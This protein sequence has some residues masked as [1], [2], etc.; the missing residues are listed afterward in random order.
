MRARRFARTCG[1]LP[2]VGRLRRPGLPLPEC[3]RQLPC[4]PVAQS[5]ADRSL[6]AVSVN[7][8]GAPP[9]K[10]A[11]KAAALQPQHCGPQHGALPPPLF[12]LLLQPFILSVAGFASQ[13]ATN[14]CSLHT[15][16]TSDAMVPNRHR[17]LLWPGGTC[18]TWVSTARHCGS[19][20]L[21][22]GG[23]LPE[24]A[25]PPEGFCGSLRLP[26]ACHVPVQQS[27]TRF[28]STT[29]P[30]QKHN[31]TARYSRRLAGVSQLL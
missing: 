26:L 2:V 3:C 14:R 17:L 7:S 11:G 19:S 4:G 16:A 20:H 10:A 31:L 12:R 22:R 9:G 23:P 5:A 1:C 15:S 29:S 18:Q 30:F 25:V 13:S 6:L 24:R 21:P 27:V 28:L 8:R